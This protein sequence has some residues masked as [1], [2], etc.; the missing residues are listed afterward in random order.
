MSSDPQSVQPSFS[1]LPE[2]PGP[3]DALS[4]DEVRTG[5]DTDPDT[6]PEALSALL[7]AEARDIP[8]L[9]SGALPPVG[10]AA[11]AG[12]PDYAH[13]LT[14]SAAEL[15]VPG[16]F[17][18]GKAVFDL[19]CEANR[20]RPRGTNGLVAFG[21]RGGLLT[22]G[23]AQ[24]G[25]EAVEI[26]DTRPD[27]VAF[28]CTLGIID[29]GTGRVR[30]YAGSTVP[31]APWMRNYFRLANGLPTEKTTRCNMLPTG[32]YIYRVGAHGGGRIDPALRMTD[33]DDLSADAKCTVLRT[34]NDLT[35]SHDDVWD[36]C[37][38]YDNIHCAYSETSFSSAGCQTI[39]GADGQGPWGA[40]Q[41]VIGGLGRGARI[42]YVLLTAREAAIAAAILDARR[43]GEAALVEACLGRLRVGSEGEIVTALQ[44]R[45]GFNGSAY[46]GPSTKKRLTEAE[47]AAG[48]A[49]DGVY[50]PAD[51]LVTGWGVFPAVAEG[52]EET[53]LSLRLRGAGTQGWVQLD[54]VTVALRPDAGL[55][56]VRSRT[57]V[58]VSKDGSDLPVDVCSCR[59]MPCLGRGP[60]SGWRSRSG[61][62]R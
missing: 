39:K 7:E 60:A 15:T 59:S 37:F 58:V 34:S 57:E 33:P 51:D 26:E 20:F 53:E 12:Q 10:W 6:S 19:L 23:D 24:E 52:P 16:R 1:G 9:E 3:N 50:S 8:A 55:G 25:V 43:E 62:S 41:R 17:R 54:D 14:R 2:D 22:G 46:F 4:G 49:T 42:D 32:C 45:L 28:R 47:G 18:F 56:G 44:R 40:F 27:H 36:P 21:L 48:L 61:P 38:P 13:T 11:D 35:F 31:N 30:A 5:A 29:T